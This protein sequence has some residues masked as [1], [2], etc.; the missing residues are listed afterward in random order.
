MLAIGDAF[1]GLGL[2]VVEL[3]LVMLAVPPIITNAY[4]GDRRAWTPIS[5]TPRGGWA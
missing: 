5:S 1:L 2:A 4:L 3:A